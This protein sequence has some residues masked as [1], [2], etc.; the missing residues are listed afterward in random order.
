MLSSGEWGFPLGS[1]LKLVLGLPST[2]TVEPRCSVKKG[3]LRNLTKFTG[4]HLCQGLFLNKGASLRPA[5]LL[6]R[7]LWQRCFPVNFAKFLRIPFLQT[8]P[9]VAASASSRF[10]KKMYPLKLL[11]KWIGQV[12][13]TSTSNCSGTYW[14]KCIIWWT[15]DWTSCPVW[16][17][18]TS[19]TAV[20]LSAPLGFCWT[21]WEETKIYWNTSTLS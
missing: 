2:E 6:K 21:L 11:E 9:L 10:L 3:V 14:D 8:A 5:T 13:A 17:C 12:K 7:G 4:K 15:F 19:E 16:V 1:G 20:P 18:Q